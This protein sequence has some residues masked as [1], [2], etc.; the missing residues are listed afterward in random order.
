VNE[1][2]VRTHEQLIGELLGNVLGFHPTQL[3]E[4]IRME[5]PWS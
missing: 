2:A 5:C 4:V 3:G 1:P